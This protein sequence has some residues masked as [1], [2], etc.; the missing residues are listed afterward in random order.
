MHQ[1]SEN[2]GK[3]TLPGGTVEDNEFAKLSLIREMLEETGIL[4]DLESLEL[5]HTLHKKKGTNTRIVL[6]FKSEKWVG[7]PISRELNKFKE[8]GWYDLQNLPKPLS[9]TVKHVLN[10]FQKKILYSEFSK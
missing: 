10:Q 8:V 1:T 9:P 5:V 2:G 3:Y 6:Y 4:V 7:K